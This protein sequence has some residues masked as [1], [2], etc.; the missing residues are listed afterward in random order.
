MLNLNSEFFEIQGIYVFEQIRLTKQK[1][2]DYSFVF[3]L[4]SAH[5]YNRL[6][7][8]TF[9]EENENKLAYISMKHKS[10]KSMW[11]KDIFMNKWAIST[12]ELKTDR[13]FKE[14]DNICA[15]QPH[16]HP[17]L[18]KPILKILLIYGNIFRETTFLNNIM[19]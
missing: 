4:N 13:I 12:R 1:S 18:F 11:F 9:I 7:E 6:G 17:R 3:N 16:C 2:L 8:N 5:F 14:D 19:L 15:N 10:L